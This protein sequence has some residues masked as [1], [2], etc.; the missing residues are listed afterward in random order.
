M[1]L[2]DGILRARYRNSPE[3]QEM[4]RPGEVYELTVEPFPTANVFKKGHRIRVEVSSSDFPLFNRN[5]NT[6]KNPYTS[7]EMVKASQ[8]ICHDSQHPSHIVLPIIKR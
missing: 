5:L 4:M 8:T 6:G 1:N 3:K 7:T 2:T